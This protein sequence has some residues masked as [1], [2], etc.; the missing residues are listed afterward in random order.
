MVT[1][2]APPPPHRCR[3]RLVLKVEFD[4]LAAFHAHY[5]RDLS[6]GG[7]RI[8]SSMAVDQRFELDISVPGFGQPL[9]IEA[10]V[11]WSL[12]AKHPDGPAAG[13]A[14]LD[15][16]REATA[17]LRDVLDAGARTAAAAPEPSLR[18]LLLEVQ[19]FL[20]EIY[21]R[22][23]RNWAELHEDDPL[24]LVALDDPAAWLDEVTRCSATIGIVDVDWLPG[25]GLP[26]YQRARA[27]VTSAEL[28]LVLIGSP[29]NLEP[30]AAVRDDRL[31]CL[32]KPL[33]FGAL[34]NTVRA[35]AC[36]SS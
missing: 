3:Q 16:S 2:S 6:G 27:N 26:L 21:G 14:F 5:L 11:Q 9:R 24:E 18:V 32:C 33:K 13:L 30:T 23:V 1:R 25:A 28:A 15:P 36:A 12:P 29:A 34:M 8:A 17:W 35:L 10:V 7:L 19:P 20:R 22:E 4:D 31:R